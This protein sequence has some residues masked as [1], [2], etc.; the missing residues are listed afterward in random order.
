ML[1]DSDSEVTDVVE[2]LSRM[3]CGTPMSLAL[4]KISAAVASY[5]FAVAMEEVEKLEEVV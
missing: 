2:E 3:V 4:D 1:D 5:D